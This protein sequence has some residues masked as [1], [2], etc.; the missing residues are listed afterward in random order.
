MEPFPETSDRKSLESGEVLS[1]RFNS[2]GLV[3]VVATD[4]ESGVLLMHAWMNAEALRQTLERGEAVYWSRSR[5]ELWHKGATSGH[6][7]R[8]REIRIDCDQDTLWLLVKQDGPGCCHVG[9]ES[10][11][12]RRVQLDE[13]GHPTLVFDR[14]RTYD[15]ED[16]Y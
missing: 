4:H 9:Y 1:P 11:F 13:H 15:P 10:C 7:Q 16:V 14:E 5:N 6:V 12:Y 2:D 8:V 3:P